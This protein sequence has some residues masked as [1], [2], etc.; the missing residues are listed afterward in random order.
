[1]KWA[2]DHSRM[3][4]VGMCAALATLIPLAWMQYRLIDQMSDAENE[5]MH[6]HLNSAVQRLSRDF[7]SEIARVSRVMMTGPSVSPERDMEELGA[8]YLR[9]REA[10]ANHQIVR[11]L[12][13]AH[14]PA[15]GDVE[16][17][18]FNPKENVFEPCAW[19]ARLELLWER[20]RSD[21]P[22]PPL[23][24]LSDEVPV[25]VTPRWRRHGPEGETGFEARLAI[26]EMD[27]AYIKTEFLPELVKKNLPREGSLDYQV[28]VVKRGSPGQVLYV[29]DT[30]LPADFFDS[31]DSQSP[32]LFT[33]AGMWSFRSPNPG[34][35]GGPDR[36]RERRPRGDRAG[37]GM[38]FGGPGSG[39]EHG[40]G[41]ER[42]SGPGPGP[43]MDGPPPRDFA[44]T[45]GGWLLQVKH[46]SGSLEEVV[47]QARRRNLGISFAILLI[48]GGTL[49]MLLVSTRRAQQ[50]AKLQ[51]EFVAGVSHELRTPLSVICSAGDNLADGVVGSEQQ[52]R[53]YGSVIRN[54][55][56]RLSQMVEQILGFAGIQSGRT[57]YE[58]Q[59]VD[60][61]QIIARAMN[62]C[63]PEILASGCELETRIEPNLPLVS[64]DP[65]SLVHCLRNLLDN[66]ARYGRAGDWIG[67]FAKA[68]NG[69]KGTEIEIRIEDHGPGI[70][71]REI[72]RIFD[73]FYRGQ[74]SVED[75][76]HGF[77]LGLALVKRI[78]DAHCGAVTVDSTPGEGTSFTIRIPANVQV[79]E[80]TEITAI[81]GTEYGG[82]AHSAD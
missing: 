8:R 80:S 23:Q 71:P 9:W 38:G 14:I 50:L 57:R 2:K 29:S 10:D 66:A 19:P 41:S 32:L 1:M 74:K 18:R 78:V 35:R 51:M 33:R 64:G 17:S 30:T 4:Y 54:E 22:G 11:D 40:P 28:R 53:R 34:D 82:T 45:R 52:I 7:E 43:G 31:V 68:I 24:S 77:G 56:R 5:R 69:A 37:F 67:V 21:A 6:V 20:L 75:Q 13:M 60:M 49:L 72:A 65:T 62:A 76:I 81:A 27:L 70:E 25:M 46:R 47:A 63:E 59:P 16:L 48:M 55:G 73:P 3:W 36:P 58:M 12:Y 15:A 79:A 61:G 44:E 39:P 26:A 42:G